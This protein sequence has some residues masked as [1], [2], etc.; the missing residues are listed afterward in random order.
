MKQKKK[1][2]TI[3]VKKYFDTPKPTRLLKRIIQIAT[4][5]DSIVLDA[6]AGSGTTA[7]SVL[8]T[9]LEDNGNRKFILVE[10]MDYANDITAQRSKKGYFWLFKKKKIK[11]MF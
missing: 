3:L 10:M 6:F 9:N 11:K 7:H 5:K 1:I 2:K 4:N 8:E